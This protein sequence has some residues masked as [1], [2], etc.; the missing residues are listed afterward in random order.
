MFIYFCRHRYILYAPCMREHIGWLDR[1]GL[2]VELPHEVKITGK[3]LLVASGIDYSC[4]GG[5]IFLNPLFFGKS[6]GKA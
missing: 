6:I 4:L 1:F 2:I 5:C 3:R